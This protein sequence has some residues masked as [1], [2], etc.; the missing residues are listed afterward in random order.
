MHGM[1][2]FMAKRRGCGRGQMRE[3]ACQEYDDNNL[4]II[5]M[6]NPS[7]QVKNDPE[8]YLV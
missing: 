4:G 5:K 6:K 7:F 3:Q 2:R 1:D 8:L